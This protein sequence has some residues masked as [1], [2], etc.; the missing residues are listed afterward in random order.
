MK[1]LILGLLGGVALMVPM[2]QSIVQLAISYPLVTRYSIATKNTSQKCP[3][4]LESLTSLMLEDLPNYTNR[5]IRQSSTPQRSNRTRR[6]V[7]LAGKPE[8][9][10][11]PLSQN[12]YSPLFSESPEQVFFT[13]LERQYLDDRVLEVQ[14]YHW[15]FLSQT[16]SGWRLVMLFSRLGSTSKARPPLPPRET[17]NSAIGQAVRLWLRDCRAGAIRPIEKSK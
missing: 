7:I 8:F 17:S 14:N 6:S 4:D 3:V 10:P 12:Q 1:L 15:L 13:T 16:K 5:V 11:L 9:E 2:L